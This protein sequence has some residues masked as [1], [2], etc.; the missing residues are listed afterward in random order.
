ML[1]QKCISNHLYT[2]YFLNADYGFRPV[3]FYLKDP[4]LLDTDLRK[5]K[6]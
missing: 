4:D 6:S 1:S 3:T 2:N 5:Q